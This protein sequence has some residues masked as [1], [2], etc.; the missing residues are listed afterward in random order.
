MRN[1][2]FAILLTFPV[3]FF[4][5]QPTVVMAQD[6]RA[7]ANVT[8]EFEVR[9]SQEQ[10]IKWSD[11]N[12]KALQD[13]LNIEIVEDMGK[14]KFKVKREYQSEEFIWIMQELTGTT[15]K[16]QYVYKS[17]L[18]D[19]VA[20][21]VV[22]AE[23]YIILTKQG[24]GTHVKIKMTAG[25]NNPAVTSGKMTIDFANRLNK[26]RKLMEHHLGS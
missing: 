10:T 8:K 11:D 17:K 22:Y 5:G 4:V 14:G 21:G 18:V 7:T 16:G 19:S 24:T 23:T 2:I 12:R 25:I 9:T 20:G 26:C 1:I 6:A 15:T 13:A 3:S